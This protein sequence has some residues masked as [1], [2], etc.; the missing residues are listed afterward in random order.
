[1]SDFFREMEDRIRNYDLLCHPFYKAWSAGALTR[2]DLQEYARNYYHQVEAFP[3]YLAQLASRLPD[4]ELR[5][6]V[7]ANRA[8]ELGGPSERTHADLWLDFAAGM[9]AT[10][11]ACASEPV[12]EVRELTTFFHQLA[13]HATPGEA[14]A[15]F[16]AY[17]SQVPRLAI[18]KA[19]GLRAMY[20]A[21]EKTCAYFTLHATADVFHANAWRR[22]LEKL[23]VSN[24]SIAETCLRAAEDASRALWRA[25]DGIAQSCGL[26]AALT[27][28]AS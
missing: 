1:M 16:Y 9:G 15:A 22:Q 11:E 23:L 20:G 8:D 27:K 14:L 17:E 3:A 26:T 21:D 6:A 28:Q 10:R 13:Q 24:S 12:S 18:E 4:G 25:L 19:R 5:R 7:E 2:T